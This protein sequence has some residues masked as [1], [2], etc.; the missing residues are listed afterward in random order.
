MIKVAAIDGEL[1]RVLVENQ[2]KL[3]TLVES[4]VL[5]LDYGTITI[6]MHNGQVQSVHVEKRTYQRKA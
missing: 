5:E 6:N 3:R 2:E 4:G 1:W